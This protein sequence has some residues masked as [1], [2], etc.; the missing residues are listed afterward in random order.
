MLFNAEKGEENNK[1]KLERFIQEKKD[2]YKAFY[3]LP[4]VAYSYGSEG[5]ALCFGWAW[6]ICILWIFKKGDK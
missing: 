5:K 6:W 3:I 1:M 2:P 4:I